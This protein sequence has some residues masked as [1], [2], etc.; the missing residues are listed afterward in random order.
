MIVLDTADELR[1]WVNKLR[2]GHKGIGFVPTM[3][4][5]H[6]GH[7][8]LVET[9]LERNDTV[10]CS[11]F[12]NPLQF[13]PEED[14]ETYPRSPEQDH[15]SLQAAGCHG[16]FL[17]SVIEIYGGSLKD[18]TSIHVPGLSDVLCGKSRPDHFDGVATV[19]AKLF[20]LVRPDD[21]YFGLK[22]YQQF[23]IIQKMVRDLALPV[24]LLGVETVRERTGLAM[25][26]RNNYLDPKQREQATAIYQ[27][28]SRCA[29]SIRA[30]ARNYD[31]LERESVTAI[32]A[33]GLRPDYFA[34][35]AASTLRRA[36]VADDELVILAAAYIGRNRLIDNLRL[37]L[38][39]TA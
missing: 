24:Q 15:A 4:N 5:L 9:A 29:E 11:I 16:L 19:V 3:G 1:S 22:D 6:R 10:I 34:V 13:G 23:L 33:A 38:T 30:G 31:Q 12:I 14:L 2:S 21:A 18:H 8:R 20:N 27:T 39:Q 17:P 32:A 28:L 36:T 35:C 25:S 26:S 7:M 37:T